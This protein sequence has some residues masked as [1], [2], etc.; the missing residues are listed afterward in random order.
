MAGVSCKKA[1][2]IPEIKA[3][4]KLLKEYQIIVYD[5]E[6]RNSILF[7][8]PDRSKCIILYKNHH[9]FDTI[10]P[11]K[12]PAFFGKKHQCPKCKV[13]LNSM[14]KHGCFTTCNTCRRYNCSANDDKIINL[15][16]STCNMFC[17]TQDCFDFHKR[18]RKN[19]GSEIPSLCETYFLCQECQT[20]VETQRRSSHICH[21]IKCHICKQYVSK[22]HLCYMQKCDPKEP[23]DKL[24][25]LDFECSQ[26]LGEHI[27]NFCVLQDVSGNEIIFENAGDSVIDQVCEHLFSERYQ[28]FSVLSH[29]GG[30]YDNLFLLRWLLLNRPTV[31]I[32][33]I[34]NGQKVIAVFINDYKIRLIDSFNW[35]SMSLDKLTKAFSLGE[36]QVKGTFPHGF[37]TKENWN[38]C[39]EIPDLSYFMPDQLSEEKRSKLIAWHNQLRETNYIFD[40]Q[41]E[42]KVYCS[43]D[44]TILRTA[45]LK[46]RNLFLSEVSIDP[47]RYTTIAGTCLATYK[48]KYMPE[49]HIAIVPKHNYKGIQKQY[50]KESIQWLDFVM[51]KTKKYIRH[52]LNSDALGEFTIFDPETGRTF[53]CDG[54]SED[55]E[56]GPVILEY[57]GCFFHACVACFD[58]NNKIYDSSS[59]TV[60]ERYQLTIDRLKRIE[61]LGYKVRIIWS[62]DFEKLIKT[63]EMKFFLK[64]HQV[65]TGLEPRECLYGGRCEGFKLYH[66]CKDGEKIR[67]L[68]FT[69]LYPYVNKSKMYPKGHPIVLTK[70][71]ESIDNYFGLIKCKILPP[72]NCLLPL[73]PQRVKL[74]NGDTKL[75][76]SLCSA[77]ATTGDKICKHSPYDRALLGSWTTIEVQ[78]AVKLGYEILEIYEIWHFE[79]TTDTLFKEYVDYFVKRKTEASGFPSGIASQIDKDNYINEF[80]KSE[81]I[82]LDSEKIEKNPGLRQLAKSCANNLWGRFAMR[83]DRL[84]TEFVHDQIKFFEILNDVQNEIHDIRILTD[85]SVEI[86]YKKLQDRIPENKNTNIFIGIFTTAWARL[87]LFEV[88]NMVG[89]DVLYC[90]TDSCIFIDRGQNNLPP[91]GPLIGDLVDEISQ[92]YG[93]NTY[94]KTFL[95]LGPKNYSLALSNDKFITKIKGFT[96]NYR[97]K[98]ILNFHT[99]KD[100]VENIKTPQEVSIKNP[101]QIH[102]EKQ[103][104]KIVT[105]PTEKTYRLV[106]DKRIIQDDLRNTIPFGYYWEYDAD[107]SQSSDSSQYNGKLTPTTMLFSTWPPLVEEQLSAEYD[108]EDEQNDIPSMDWDEEQLSTEYD[109]ED[110]QNEIPSMDWDEEQLSTEPFDISDVNEGTYGIT[111]EDQERNVTIDLL[112]TSDESDSSGSEHSSDIEFMNDDC[113]DD[114]GDVSFYRR[115]M[116]E[117]RMNEEIHLSE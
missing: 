115:L 50:S 9:H 49:N 113:N 77:C 8:G 27:P 111:S 24:L 35:L 26:N 97:N 107:I 23:D 103:T 32:Q 40:F 2:G 114:D 102:R 76:F 71:F 64:T 101:S 22:D 92:E 75:L 45:C 89:K 65:V 90:D 31:D 4:Q 21:E 25:F 43:Q 104:R 67:Y 85:E 30:K 99:L 10:N 53:H 6:G 56:D 15:T 74:K 38:Y 59:V 72:A 93:E 12:L 42:M 5:Y 62:H 48:S 33:C 73:L 83:T 95:C 100:I 70:D 41:K 81:G 91:T 84:H 54:F 11:Y 96:L 106:F 60:G 34:N 78:K 109:T 19:K 7:Q 79:E 80:E 57:L 86:T 63:D 66:N 1:C 58:R 47:F 52:A 28:N 13:F 88:L 14:E 116:N 87:E 17:K 18:S 3:F 55:F 20:I 16:C 108:T 82:K 61:E 112:N 29:Y 94:I 46:F 37:N 69:S 36:G 68:D 117:E 98:Q 105:R 110:E 51:H 39:G 44:V